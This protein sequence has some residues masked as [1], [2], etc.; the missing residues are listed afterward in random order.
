MNRLTEQCKIA[1]NLRYIIPILSIITL[2]CVVPE[3]S[4]AQGCSD[5]GICSAP[6]IKLTDSSVLSGTKK[7]LLNAGFT[8]GTSQYN[9]KVL[10]VGVEYSR[11]FGKHFI[12]SAKYNYAFVSGPLSNNIGPSDILVTGAYRVK[13]FTPMV[14]V[15]IPMSHANKID[16]GLPLPMSYQTS[17]GT[18]DVLAGLTYSTSVWGVSVAWQQP[19]VQNKSSFFITDYA[20][21]AINQ[22]YVSTNGFVRKAD[23]IAKAF[24]N[25]P[26]RNKRWLFTPGLLP[27]FHTANDTWLNKAGQRNEITGSQGLT[28]NTNVALTYTTNPSLFFRLTVGAPALARKVR[29]EGLTKFA[30]ILEYTA[31]L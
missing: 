26:F 7:N 9:V 19:V 4:L 23:V 17:L 2:S 14:G 3:R 31:K 1:F 11:F 22:K 24:Y 18:T 28:L 27:I 10:S 13:K 5:A 25:I 12:A 15:K 21:D 6:T 20:A 16:G 29:P 8:F 30:V